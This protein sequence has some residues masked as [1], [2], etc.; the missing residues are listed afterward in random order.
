VGTISDQPLWED[1]AD[2]LRASIDGGEYDGK[3]LPSEIDLAGQH[4]VSRDTVRRAL[5]RL[6]EEGLLTSGRGRLGRQVRISD[7]LTFYAIPS[8]SAER[9]AERRAAG[10]DAWVADVADQGRVGAQEISVAIEE[11][12]PQVAGRLELGPG[13]LVCVRRH[14]RT[15]DGEPHNI[16]DT[17]YPRSISE[18]TLIEHPADVPQGV[19]AYMRDLGYD[20]VR[21]RDD[22]KMRMP[23][24]GEA[25]RLQIPPGVPV[26]AQYRTGYTTERPVKVTV[27]VWPGDRTILRYDFPA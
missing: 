12:R 5:R 21:F 14:L 22:L 20:Q 9:V 4:H 8:E 2:A 11:P 16:S 23:T 10:I 6:T 17:H 13:E 3:K 18:G 1:V 24:P 27:T 25:E 7:P 15:V 26:L 19:I